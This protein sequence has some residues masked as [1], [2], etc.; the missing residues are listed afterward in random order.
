MKVIDI[1]AKKDLHIYEF[2][3]KFIT[4]ILI[5][6]VFY[7][8]AQI[9]ETKNDLKKFEVKVAQEYSRIAYREDIVR[10]EQKLDDLRKLIIDEIKKK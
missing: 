7:L 3:H 10:L 9:N 8:L 2:A 4:G 1:M 5:P 6:V